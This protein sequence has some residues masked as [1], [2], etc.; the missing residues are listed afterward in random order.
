MGIGEPDPA[1]GKDPLIVSEQRRRSTAMIDVEEAAGAAPPDAQPSPLEQEYT[2]VN[3]NFRRLADIRFRLL[4]FVPALGGVA[5][6]VL[7]TAGLSAESAPRQPTNADLWLVALIAAVG[8]FVTL[9]IVFYDQRNSELYDA[10]IHRAKVLE[11]RSKLPRSPGATKEGSVGGQFNERPRSDRHLFGIEP[12]KMSHDTGLAL[13]YGP[14]LGAWFFPLLLSTLSLLGTSSR[15]SLL[16]ACF[17]A[18]VAGVVFTVHLLLIDSADNIR[19]NMAGLIDTLAEDIRD[20]LSQDAPD[21]NNREAEID[22]ILE[23][24]GNLE[25]KINFARV[26]GGVPDP[27]SVEDNDL[28]IEFRYI[29]GPDSFG[30]EVD[31]IVNNIKNDRY[32]KKCHILLLAYDPYQAITDDR[33]Y[34][35]CIKKLKDDASEKL[36][37]LCTVRVVKPSSRQ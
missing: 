2:Q 36:K 31:G 10:L 13:T 8:F 27:S 14:V 28:L 29:N 15:A 21:E 23:E 17:V 5:V 32:P 7:A 3:E 34:K 37:G 26:R 11:K 30:R 16:L 18:A 20:L 33:K 4:A 1:H 35:A 19:W 9:G 12:F 25:E 22:K 24:R 6:Y